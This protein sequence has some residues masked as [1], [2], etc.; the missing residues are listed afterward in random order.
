MLK[1]EDKYRFSKMPFLRFYL[2]WTEMGEVFVQR[3]FQADL[4]TYERRV[5]DWDVSGRHNDLILLYNDSM[6]ALSFRE[7]AQRLANF[8]E[9]NNISKYSRVPKWR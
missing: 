4:D 1:Y 3:V 6:R 5:E 2:C 9:L 8:C 7:V